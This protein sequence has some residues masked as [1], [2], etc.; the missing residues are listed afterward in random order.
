MSL[1]IATLTQKDEYWATEMERRIVKER[2]VVN[3]YAEKKLQ[4]SVRKR[5]STQCQSKSLPPPSLTYTIIALLLA[6][7]R[8]RT[9]C[10]AAP[11]TLPV[12]KP[13]KR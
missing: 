13:L 2:A 3:A 11:S 6:G 4:E 8:G 1:Q 9:G 7:R 5:N 12:I 10:A